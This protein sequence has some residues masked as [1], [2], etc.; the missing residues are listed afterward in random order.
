MLK[1]LIPTGTELELVLITRKTARRAEKDCP[2]LKNIRCSSVFGEGVSRHRL[3]C[4]REW[5]RRQAR[6]VDVRVFPGLFGK[7]IIGQN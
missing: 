7:V 5:E 3:V 6:A 1:L 4:W 2:T